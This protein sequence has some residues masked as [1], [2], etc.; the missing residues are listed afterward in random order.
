L[1]SLQRALEHC[2]GVVR[3]LR[4]LAGVDLFVFY[5]YRYYQTFFGLP[6][7]RDRAVLV[8]TAEEDAAI[9]LP[10]FRSLAEAIVGSALPVA[11]ADQTDPR[12]PVELHCAI[13]VVAIIDNHWLSAHK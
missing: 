5:S 6:A 7:V 11:F 2:R 8:P 3:S 9:E 4:T 12:E 1:S 13:G 10:V